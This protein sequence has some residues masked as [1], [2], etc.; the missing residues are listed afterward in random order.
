[1]TDPESSSISTCAILG[2]QSHVLWASLPQNWQYSFLLA[3]MTSRSVTSPIRISTQR[4]QDPD[5]HLVGKIP[6]WKNVATE[7]QSDH[8]ALY[9]AMRANVN[10]QVYPVST[11]HHWKP[12]PS[13]SFL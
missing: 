9:R 3:R 6:R 7:P 13:A 10:W 2:Q 1:M 11:F 4:S 5:P 12:S 8:V